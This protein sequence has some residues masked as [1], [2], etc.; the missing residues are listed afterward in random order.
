MFEFICHF[1][2]LRSLVTKAHNK[3]SFI[4]IWQTFYIPFYYSQ[5]NINK[6]SDLKKKID[7]Q[8]ERLV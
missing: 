5:K 4:K 1:V 3:C 8:C 7:T 2:S 6:G